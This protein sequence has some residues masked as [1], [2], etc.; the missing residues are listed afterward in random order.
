MGKDWEKLTASNEYS[1][2]K[3]QAA[4]NWETPPVLQASYVH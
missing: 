3:I 2:I 4:E 1:T